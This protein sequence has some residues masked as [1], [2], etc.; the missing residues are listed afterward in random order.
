MLK[1]FVAPKTFHFFCALGK[2]KNFVA[3][4]MLKISV[5]MVTLK[6]SVA[7]V[8]LKNS[9]AM[10]TLKNSVALKFPC[11]SLPQFTYYPGPGHA[12]DNIVI[13][14]ETERVLYGWCLVKSVD[15]NSLGNLSDANVPAYP[16][17][18]RNVIN[19]CKRPRYIIPGH[20]D[21]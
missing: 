5:A 19:K 20:N 21:W 4:V 1:I 7:L 13:W 8:T 3:L 2:P 10:V 14:F 11:T 9:V 16:K 6:N 17:T 15:D 18:I 12:S